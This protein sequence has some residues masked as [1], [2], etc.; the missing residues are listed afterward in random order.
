M[1]TNNGVEGP[2]YLEKYTRHIEN[3]KELYD[4]EWR[5]KLVATNGNTKFKI[6]YYGELCWDYIVATDFS[7]PL[8][9][10]VEPESGEEILLFDGCK[11]GY[12]PMLCDQ[13]TPEQA[14]NRKATDWYIDERNDLF[15]LTIS[16]YYQIDFEEE[17]R[18]QVDEMGNIK[19]DY[20]EDVNFE[21]LKRNGYDCLIIT[22]VAGNGKE[23]ELALYELA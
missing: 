6:K 9:Y 22:A 17:M 12:N 21:E 15:E 10:A 4:F 1:N 18:D 5:R 14:S 19:S 8:I 20:G 11:H 3:P 2:I 13:Y 7:E 16:T 23:I